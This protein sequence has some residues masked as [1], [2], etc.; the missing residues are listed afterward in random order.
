MLTLTDLFAGAG[1]SSTGASSVPGVSVIAASNHWRLAIEVHEANHPSATHI[2]ADISQI[3]PRAYPRS[4]ILWAS[5]ECTN[6]SGARGRRNHTNQG[7]LFPDAREDLA[8]RSRATMWDVPRFTEVHEYHAIIVEN[9]IEATRWR[10]YQAW[11]AAMRSLGYQHEERYLN[12]MHA[13]ALGP[14]APQSRDRLYVVF[15]REG[16]RR[17]DLDHWLAPH[18]HCPTCGAVRARQTWKTPH[19][20]GRYGTQ[21]IYTCP[22]CNTELTPHA[23]P[24]STA[25]DPSIPSTRISDRDTPLAPN[26]IARI[27]AGIQRYWRPHN[28]QHE[29][30]LHAPHTT[31]HPH[32]RT[33]LIMRNNSTHEPGAWT[34]TPTTE[35]LRTLT[36]SGHQSLLSLDHDAPASIENVRYRMLE[37]HEIAAGMAFPPDYVWAGTKRERKKLAGNAVTPPAARDLIACVTEAITGDTPA[38]RA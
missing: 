25:I 27:N 11:L 14:A 5:P 10:P 31:P 12:S 4:T 32:E 23:P 22:A 33:P 36:T 37:P 24:A 19:H 16:Q 8:E 28:Q 15:W 7:A 29:R 30:L 35:P 2:C 13:T 20:W 3:S 1:G 26:T 17:P 6:H 9:V 38:L 18:A 34:C 21:Y